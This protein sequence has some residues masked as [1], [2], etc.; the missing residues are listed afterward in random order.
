MPWRKIVKLSGVKLHCFD[1]KRKNQ[2]KLNKIQMR[3]KGS[4]P[5]AEYDKLRKIALKQGKSMKQF[6]EE[7]RVLTDKTE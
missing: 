6:L 1:C 2:K 3:K 4:R 5:K 7:Y